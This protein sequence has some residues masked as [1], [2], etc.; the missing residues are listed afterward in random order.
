MHSVMDCG[1]SVGWLRISIGLLLLLLLILWSITLAKQL[2]FP[3]RQ[4]NQTT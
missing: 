3:K 1:G 4:E 2:F